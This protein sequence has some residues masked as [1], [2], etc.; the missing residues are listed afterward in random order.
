MWQ[1]CLWNACSAL[2]YINVCPCKY[3]DLCIGG[4]LCVCVH[5]IKVFSSESRSKPSS[6]VDATVK[7]QCQ[8]VRREQ[9]KK[10]VQP[11]EKKERKEYSL[12]NAAALSLLGPLLL[13]TSVHKYSYTRL[14]KHCLPSGMSRN[15][16]LKTKKT[17]VS[18]ATEILITVTQTDEN[19]KVKW[20]MVW[21]VL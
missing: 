11:P 12:R 6:S 13:S 8:R 20:V 7:S 19:R 17:S 2:T 18:T 15:L 4:H 16:R 5:S 9:R 10:G 21:R 1:L 3:T 14:I